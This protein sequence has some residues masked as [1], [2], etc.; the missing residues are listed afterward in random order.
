ML[1]GPEKNIPTKPKNQHKEILEIWYT[2]LM[3][4]KKK[5]NKYMFN[6]VYK[7]NDF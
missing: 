2:K 6:T 3:N 7:V 1:S 5:S 4:K